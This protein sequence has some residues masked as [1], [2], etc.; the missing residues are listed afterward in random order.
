MNV[1][2]LENRLFSDVLVK[3]RPFWIRVGSKSSMT[4]V[5]IRE[6]PMWIHTEGRGPCEDEGKDRSEADTKQG[7][8]G[9]LA[10]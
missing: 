7:Y 9:L 4:D 3:M 2:L 6:K 10:T 8:Q 5:L 1:I